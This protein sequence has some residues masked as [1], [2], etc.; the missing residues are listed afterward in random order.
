MGA[1]RARG[2][3]NMSRRKWAV[4]VTAAALADSGSVSGRCR[5]VFGSS[6]VEES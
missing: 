1:R 5:V 3:D 6:L 2:S 4:A